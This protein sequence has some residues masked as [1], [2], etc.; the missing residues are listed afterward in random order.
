MR[1]EIT[2]W[3]HAPYHM[4]IPDPDWEGEY[5]ALCGSRSSKFSYIVK[6]FLGVEGFMAC[7]A[8]RSHPDLPLL[9]LA[10]LAEYE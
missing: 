10:E 6:F 7:P 3:R 9:A 5:V 1:R 4:A 8:C 2:D